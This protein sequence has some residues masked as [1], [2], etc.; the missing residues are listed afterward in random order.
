MDLLTIAVMTATATAIAARVVEL[1]V[2]RPDAFPAML[3]GARRF[4]EGALAESATMRAFRIKTVA[5]NDSARP[6]DKER[7]P[8]AA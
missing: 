3:G 2:R 5:A 1:A 7:L 6:E 4:A 8:L